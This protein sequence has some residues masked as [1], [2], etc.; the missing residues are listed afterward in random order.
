MKPYFA[1]EC[2][3]LARYY[4]DSKGDPSFLPDTATALVEDIKRYLVANALQHRLEDVVDI[5]IAANELAQQAL[6]QTP[7]VTDPEFE[8]QVQ[9]GT[10]ANDLAMQQMDEVMLSRQVAGM[11]MSEF[12]ANRERFG[13]QRSVIDFLQGR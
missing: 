4:L 6:A 7:P 12:G 2:A 3:D 5:A 8:A 10:T 9:Q 13:L 1:I 11:S